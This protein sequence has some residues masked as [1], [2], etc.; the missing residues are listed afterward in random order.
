MPNYEVV[1]KN[2]KPMLVASRRIIIPTN[3]QVPEY[4][5]PAFDEVVGFIKQHKAETNGPC[6]A[7]WHSSPDT[8]IDEDVEVIFPIAAR[9]PDNDRVKVYELASNEVAAVI[10]QGDFEEFT[11][12][13]THLK[14]WLEANGFRLNGPYR[15][16]YHDL[17]DRSHATVE[18]QFPIEKI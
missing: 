3:D 5:G 18:V 14:Q 13:H 2:T 17:K 16:I 6:L 9:V 15:E 12:G 7:L 8:L 1:I 11:N 10:H 4:I